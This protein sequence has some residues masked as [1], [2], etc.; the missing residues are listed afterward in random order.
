MSGGK[1]GAESRQGCSIRSS[2]ANEAASQEQ[3]EAQ[4]K[5]SMGN[6][7]GLFIP[8]QGR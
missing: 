7:I 6:V 8:L 4:H 2:R 1:R 3:R 5:W